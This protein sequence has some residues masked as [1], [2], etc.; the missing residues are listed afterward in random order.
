MQFKEQ[1]KIKR[2]IVIT[3]KRVSCLTAVF[4]TD[5]VKNRIKVNVISPGWVITDMVKDEPR[6]GVLNEK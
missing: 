3:K 2:F 4:G 1:F 6:I 5:W